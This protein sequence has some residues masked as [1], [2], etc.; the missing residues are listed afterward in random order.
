MNNTFKSKFL[1]GALAFSATLLVFGASTGCSSRQGYLTTESTIDQLSPGSFYIAPK[2]D[3]ILAED[4]SG[5]RDAINQQVLAQL[6]QFLRDLES[7]GW[8]Y[9]FSS[10]GLGTPSYL[11]QAIASRHDGNWGSLWTAAYPGAPQWGPDTLPNQIFRR[12]EAYSRFV[13]QGSNSGAGNETG[14]ATIRSSL[15]E[16]TQNTG[17]IRNDA[18]LVVV[19]LSNGEDTSGVNYCQRF[20]GQMVPCEETPSQWGASTCPAH[21]CTAESSFQYYKNEIRA[22]KSNA[23]M[24]RMFA[25]VSPSANSNCMGGNAY[26]GSRYMRLANELGGQSIDICSQQVSG[27][28]GAIAQNLQ[29]IRIAQRT[30]Y[31]FVPI[32]VEPS[33][34]RVRKYLTNGSVVDVPMDPANGFT[35]QGYVSNVYAI[36]YPVAMNLSSG[37]AIELHGSAKLSGDER[38]DVTYLPRGAQDTTN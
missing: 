12:P 24:I 15:W 10:V 9:H 34:L 23:Q 36:D 38:A 17:I 19:A 1:T 29:G 31:L 2:V 28:L 26:R 35:Y 13:A 18:L 5:S 32:D 11:D 22:R 37:Y 20:G 6:P 4:D 16:N 8:N 25:A 30:R 33:S 21:I 7:R 27:V 3:I 14:L